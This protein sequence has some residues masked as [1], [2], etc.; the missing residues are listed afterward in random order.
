MGCSWA[1]HHGWIGWRYD[2]LG[3]MMG[4]QRATGHVR[5]SVFGEVPWCGLMGCQ[6]ATHPTLAGSVCG[7]VS[8]WGL[9]GCQRATHPTFDVLA[10]VGGFSVGACNSGR[11]QRTGPRSM[12]VA[13]AAMLEQGSVR[14]TAC[15]ASVVAVSA[16]C[17][18]GAAA[19]A[20]C[21]LWSFI[22][23]NVHWRSRM[24]PAGDGMAWD[25][26]GVGGEND[27]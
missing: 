17:S 3:W 26:R 16:R 19:C 11:S 21:F 20:L 25:L 6:R 7:E 27:P 2:L 1:T 18:A 14:A 22:M 5:G 8:W 10:A 23:C 9:M 12:Q 24:V 13:C 15:L 4:C